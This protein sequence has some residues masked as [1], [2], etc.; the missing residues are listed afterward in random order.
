MVISGS[1]AIRAP[2]G[3]HA[4]QT[5]NSAPT[6]RGNLEVPSSR[7]ENSEPRIWDRHVPKCRYGITSLR[8]I[9]SHKNAVNRNHFIDFNN[10]NKIIIIPI[11]IKE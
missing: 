8:C 7:V 11:L 4:A 10:I 3:Y 2:L 1:A 6:F 9:L 5:D